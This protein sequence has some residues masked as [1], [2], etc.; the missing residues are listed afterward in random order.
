ML[1][2]VLFRAERGR[3]PV[4]NVV[5]LIHVD[6]GLLP[7]LECLPAEVALVRRPGAQ[8]DGPNVTPEVVLA[9]EGRI[10]VT[11]FVFPGTR[12]VGLC[13]LRCP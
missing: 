7:L 5:T 13:V 3:T 10:A 9:R 6:L 4:T 1:E 2:L 11:T 8:V 12:I